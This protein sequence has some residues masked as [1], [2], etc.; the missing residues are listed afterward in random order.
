MSKNLNINKHIF[1]SR[2]SLNEKDHN[3]IFL[4]IATY[5]SENNEH[6]DRL[7]DYMKKSWFMPATP[8][9][10]NAGTK[11]GLPIS[12][13]VCEIQDNL[14]SILETIYEV[15][16]CTACG[17]GIG[18]DLSNIRSLGESIKDKGF[19]PGIIPFTKVIEQM[20]CTIAQGRVRRGACA[21][22]LSVYHPEIESF[23]QIRKPSGGDPDR[24]IL[25][26]HHGIVIDD[27]FINCVENNSNIDLVSPLTGL[28]IKS[29]NARELWIEILLTR[30][31]T[32]EPYILF[33]DTINKYRPNILKKLN[34]DI[35]TSN[36]C[37]EIML[38]T[39]IDHLG[40]ERISVCCLSSLNLEK[41]DEWKNDENFIHDIMLMLD[42]TLT[43]FQEKA[44]NKYLSKAIYSSLRERSVGL[45]VM[46]FH[47]YLQSKMI[48]FE[49]EEA[50]KININIFSYIKN[51]VD[52]SSYRISLEKGPCLDAKELDINERFL[53]KIAIAPTA[54]ISSIVNTSPGIEPY[55]ANAFIHKTGNG[56]FIYKNKFLEEI[57]INKNLN[58]DMI[59]TS[60]V[61]NFGSVQHLNCLN[62]HEK[63]VFKTAFEIDQKEIIN[64]AGQRTEYI[65]QS[66]SL[67]LFFY[68]TV[69]KKYLNEV[70]LLA[71]KSN[72]KSL[73]YLRS[74]SLQRAKYSSC[75]S[76]D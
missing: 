11:R 35:K 2:C 28:T 63:D 15:G 16:W 61:E 71:A 7:F 55:I 21:A 68:P 53:H 42:N 30:L 1:N 8:I 59:W 33:K 34:I 6:R 26:I 22:Y 3:D 37:S 36:L 25:N 66:Q 49:S 62:Q 65:C 5:L 27:K 47:S 54:N 46:G 13:F 41:F 38:P 69:N 12:C 45:G 31:E 29:I 19:T 43:S 57:L 48:A 67:N 58:N 70:H 4:R 64:L 74:L 44:S 23:L 76:C 56:S 20:V 24:K 50:K 17:G 75:S 39:G 72:I 51:K 73:Y 14:D 10:A 32:G 40:K 18:V 9:L 60:I 52:I